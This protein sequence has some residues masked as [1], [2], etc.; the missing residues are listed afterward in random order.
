MQIFILYNR[1]KNRIHTYVTIPMLRPN[2]YHLKKIN[3]S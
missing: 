1:M 3:F 2:F